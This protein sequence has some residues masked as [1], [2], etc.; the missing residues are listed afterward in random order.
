MDPFRNELTAAHAK[1]AQL[2]EQV[3]HLEHGR[4]KQPKRRL[5]RSM[6]VYFL[7]MTLL[8]VGLGAVTI[9]TVVAFLRSGSAHQPT[10]SARMDR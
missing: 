7:L 4:A 8:I 3:H 5:P 2:E 1:I 10:T 6:I 9:G